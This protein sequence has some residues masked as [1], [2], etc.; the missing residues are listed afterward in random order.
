MTQKQETALVKHLFSMHAGQQNAW[1]CHRYND[2]RKHDRRLVYKSYGDNGYQ[3]VWSRVLKDL[4]RNGIT[5]YQPFCG[6]SH[7]GDGSVYGLVKLI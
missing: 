7:R 1:N 6:C 4:V 3:G 5:G 2:K